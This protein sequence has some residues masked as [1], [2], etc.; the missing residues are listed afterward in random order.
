MATTQR[1]ELEPRVYQKAGHTPRTQ[2]YR[3]GKHVPVAGVVPAGLAELM[4][5][6]CLSL[7]PAAH[8]S[9]R[10]GT[11]GSGRTFREAC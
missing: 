11:L 3:R 7:A 8:G 9:R 2:Y 4:Y 1:G 10:P 5:Q 6:P